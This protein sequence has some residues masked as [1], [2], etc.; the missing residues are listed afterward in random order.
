M[1]FR[2]LIFLGILAAFSTSSAAPAYRSIRYVYDGDTILLEGGEKVRFLG[3]DAPEVGYDGKK[4]EFM[5]RAARQ[6]VRNV[7]RKSDVRLECDREKTDRHGRLLAYVFL[8]NGDMINTMLVR[9]GLAHVMLR[10]PNLKYKAVLIQCQQK[11]IRDKLGIWGRP[12]GAE[13]KFYTGSRR[14]YRFHR[15]DCPFG[16]RISEKNRIRFHSRRDAFWAGFSPCDH[17]QP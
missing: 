7:L 17:C 4:C 9:K 6:F 3:I 10:R 14:S 15:P 11:A 16:K 5:A 2:K 1:I 13:E 12:S 8:E